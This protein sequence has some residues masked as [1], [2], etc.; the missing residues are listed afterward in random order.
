MTDCDFGTIPKLMKKAISVIKPLAGKDL[1]K[2]HELKLLEK[3]L[4]TY[5]TDCSICK[6]ADNDKICLDNASNKLIRSLPFIRDSV[7]PWINYDWDYGNFI[8]NNYSTRATGSSPDG[9]NYL[10]NGLIFIKIIQAYITSANPSNRSVPGSKNNQSDYPIYGCEGNKKK[11]C[12]AA[13]IVK[14]KDK[15]DMPYDDPFFHKNISGEGSSSYF[16]KVG[17]CPRPDIKN[18]KKCIQKRYEWKSNPVEET[19]SKLTG[20]Q[21][22]SCQQ[23]RYIYLDNSPG[24]SFSIPA[25]NSNM[26]NKRSNINIKTKKVDLGKLK[27]FLPS[28]TNDIFSLSPDKL[29]NAFQG[30]DVNGHMIVQSCPDI[31]EPYENYM[32]AH[33]K[34]KYKNANLIS[35][36]VIILFIVSFILLI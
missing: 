26:K 2:K 3:A 5:L 27:G 28:L 9:N 6:K 14:V 36:L 1:Q 35:M 22:G 30:K 17:Y 18:P 10:K 33:T 11:G 20:G 19:M 25:T 8:D 16:A 15:Q 13:H 12:D 24:L 29:F 4:N 23:P 34:K 32:L 7:Y 31:K 21:S